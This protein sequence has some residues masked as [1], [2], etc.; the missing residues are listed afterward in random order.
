[1]HAS[2]KPSGVDAGTFAVVMATGIVSLAAAF[3]SWSLLSDGL[4]VLAG[5]IWLVLAATLA[6]RLLRDRSR[7]PRPHSFAVVAATGVLGARVS[8]AGHDGLA[9]ACWCLAVVFWVVLVVRRPRWN[10][11]RGSS[12]LVVVGTQSLAVLAALL[13]PRFGTGLRDVAVFAWALGL[14]LYAPV[15]VAVARHTNRRRRFTPDLWIA[16]GA[17]AITTL[18][19]SELVL[20]APTFRALR[21][22]DLVTWAV[23]TTLI[24]P[25][26][27]TELRVRSFGYEA[28]RWS[29]V[30]PLGMY[31]VASRALASAGG[32]AWPDALGHVFFPIAVAAWAVVAVGSLTATTV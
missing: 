32:G 14:A 16:M 11:V 2:P 29:F 20:A 21:P 7:R 15:I 8:L 1:M 4:F 22:I 18:A 6:R 13:V 25:L 24:V 31:S 12:L 3:E 10:D 9:F 19:G 23:A 30:F 28:S 26:A 17:L 27:L 5:A